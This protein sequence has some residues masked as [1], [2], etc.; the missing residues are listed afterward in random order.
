MIVR[1]LLV[2]LWCA[3][4]PALAQERIT[5]FDVSVEVEKDGDIVVTETIAVI[6][7]GRQIRRGVFRDL[8]RYYLKNNRKLPY[9]Y[10]V[11]RVEKNGAREPYAVEKSGNAFRIR[12]GDADVFLASGP[13]TYEI[14]YEVKNQVRYFGAYDELYWN[15]TGTYWAF[16]IERAS[17]RIALPG[18]ARALQQAAYTGPRGSTR[19]DY[20]YEF[21]NGVHGFTTTGRLQQREGM[22]VAVGFEKGVVDPPSS[23]DARAEWWALNA[24]RLVL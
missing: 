1:P 24:S 4:G 16:P 22:T 8:P 3:A 23:G 15:A 12:I 5:D 11:K 7:E 6:A 17:V 14:E 19:Q 10:D 2:V 9:A 18:G 21:L 20:A 13:Y